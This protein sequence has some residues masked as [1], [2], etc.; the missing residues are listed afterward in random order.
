MLFCCPK[1]LTIDILSQAF[2]SLYCMMHN[3][4]PD[5]GGRQLQI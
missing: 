2:N 5:D 1:N 4:V 3:F